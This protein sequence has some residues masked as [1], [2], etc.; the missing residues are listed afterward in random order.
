MVLRPAMFPASEKCPFSEASHPRSGVDRR[1]AP[2][3]A[4][5]TRL[6]AHS[7]LYY[8]EQGMGRRGDMSKGTKRFLLVAVILLLLER[9]VFYGMSLFANVL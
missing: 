3:G 9:V 1:V 2:T 7:P 5:L 8:T 6:S 4:L